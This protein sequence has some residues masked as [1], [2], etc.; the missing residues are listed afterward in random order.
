MDCAGQHQQA[1]PH[2]VLFSMYFVFQHVFCSTCILVKTY[3]H[4]TCIL[5][6]CCIF[7]DRPVD[8][9]GSSTG[10]TT[11]GFVQHA[12]SILVSRKKFQHWKQRLYPQ[13][14]SVNFLLNDNL[15]VTKSIPVCTLK[16]LS[17]PESCS[18]FTTSDNCCCSL[19]LGACFAPNS[20]ELG[21]SRLLARHTAAGNR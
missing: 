4:W 20:R 11:L 10:T 8:C 17:P 6:C 21:N 19:M 16:W 14:T 12:A 3:D 15:T 2:L 1:R 5:C 18:D 7:S 13:V 9:A